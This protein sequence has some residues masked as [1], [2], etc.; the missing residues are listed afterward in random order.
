MIEMLYV[1]LLMMIFITRTSADLCENGKDDHCMALDCP[2]NSFNQEI[3]WNTASTIHQ[4][5]AK[6]IYGVDIPLKKYNGSVLIIVNVASQCGLTDSNY[7]KLVEFYE[8]YRNKGLKI[9]AFPSNQFW[10]QEPG[11]CDEIL[12]FVKRY[13]VKFDMFGKIDINGK[14]AHPLWKWL[15]T[16]KDNATVDITWNFTK[17]I[18][19]RDGKFVERFDPSFIT[20]S[21]LILM[22]KILNEIFLE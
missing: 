20:G 21:D 22:E 14:N 9:L 18:I 12:N 8:K 1:I 2:Q 5:N 11:T 4:F 3:N 16:Q 17:F 19:D 15:T 7:K 13:N 6:D 10:N